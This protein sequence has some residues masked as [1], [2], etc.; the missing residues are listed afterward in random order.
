MY[1]QSSILQRST[2]KYV[3]IKSCDVEGQNFGLEDDKS[4][5]LANIHF[6]QA[7]ALLYVF[8][9]IQVIYRK[10]PLYPIWTLKIYSVD[11][12]SYSCPL[13]LL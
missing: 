12:V 5:I 7:I 4:S 1:V 9:N 10:Y 6:L 11:H 13:C 2:S 8:N 3:L